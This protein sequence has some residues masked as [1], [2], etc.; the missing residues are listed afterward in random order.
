[1]SPTMVWATVCYR[2]HH[3]GQAVERFQAIGLCFLPHASGFMM[4]SLCIFLVR[5]FRIENAQTLCFIA[6]FDSDVCN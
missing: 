2:L 1:M 3:E 6:S 4:L 5:C